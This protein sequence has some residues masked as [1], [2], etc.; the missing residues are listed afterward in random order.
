[1]LLDKAAVGQTLATGRE[2]LSEALSRPGR[3]DYRRLAPGRDF[4]ELSNV[5]S[6]AVDDTDSFLTM[7]MGAKPYLLCSTRVL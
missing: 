5:L 3:K 1:M 6:I 7:N 4:D 2:L